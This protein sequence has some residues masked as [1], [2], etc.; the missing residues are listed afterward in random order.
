MSLPRSIGY[1]LLYNK[2]PPKPHALKHLLFH[3]FSGSGIWS[4][5]T[6][7]CGS[8]TLSGGNHGVILG[9]SFLGLAR[10]GTAFKLK[11]RTVDRPQI[12]TDCW[13]ETSFPSHM[14]STAGQHASSRARFPSKR[15]WEMASKM[16]ITVFL[17]PNDGSDITSLLH[18]SCSFKLSHTQGETII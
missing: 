14:I 15:E 10:D 12:F 9:Q 7:F 8:A 17:Q 1:L 13:I 5:L 11:C 4:W 2:L 18:Y 6:G 3:S 16:G